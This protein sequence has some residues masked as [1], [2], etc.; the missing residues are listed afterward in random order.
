MDNKVRAEASLHVSVSRV[1]KT[2]GVAAY[3]SVD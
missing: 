1:T 3:I 2:A